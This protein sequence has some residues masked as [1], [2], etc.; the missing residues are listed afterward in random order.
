MRHQQQPIT[1]VPPEKTQTSPARFLNSLLLR[2]HISGSALLTAMD[3]S[4]V[5]P[6]L[7]IASSHQDNKG[8]DRISKDLRDDTRFI[9]FYNLVFM[10]YNKKDDGFLEL[11]KQK[12]IDTGLGLK[13]VAR[14]LQKVYHTASHLLQSTL[15]RVI[16]QET[17]QAG[18]MV[19][20][21]HLRFDF[22]FRRPVLDKKLT[23]IKGDINSFHD[24]M[25]DHASNGGTFDG[26]LD[27]E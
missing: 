24:T 27:D 5:D 9:K 4:S 22:N 11:L 3:Q 15:K 17:S 18:S 14:I 12:N 16:G 6:P 23:E 21:D 8:Q 13:C 25:G 20:F 7:D 1:T 2:Y 19:A 10:Q 26:P